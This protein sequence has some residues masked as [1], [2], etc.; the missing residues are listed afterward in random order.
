MAPAM[1]IRDAKPSN[2]PKIWL[3]T[4][5]LALFANWGSD[6]SRGFM[7]RVLWFVYRLL[8]TSQIAAIEC[9]E[10]GDKRETYQHQE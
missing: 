2:G 10:G 1:R 8:L 6:C 7:L 4:T 3:V 5:L 9:R